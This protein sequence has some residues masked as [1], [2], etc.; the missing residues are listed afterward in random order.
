MPDYREEATQALEVERVRAFIDKYTADANFWEWLNTTAVPLGLFF[1]IGRNL[2][3]H[4]EMYKLSG[5]RQL[6]LWQY[7]VALEC[8]KAERR[9]PIMT[10][11]DE[12]SIQTAFRSPSN[13]L[14]AE[15]ATEVLNSAKLSGLPFEAQKAVFLYYLL[16]A[17]DFPELRETVIRVITESVDFFLNRAFLSAAVSAYQG[18]LVKLLA[19]ACLQSAD[20]AEDIAKIIEIATARKRNDLSPKDYATEIVGWYDEV[21]K[22][23]L[24]NTDALYPAPPF[25]PFYKLTDV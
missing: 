16:A 8:D 7:R 12:I 21:E 13:L 10:R 24:V 9:S 4:E 5:S 14:I 22:R 18:S 17:A 1:A 20:R 25:I 11:L 15:A 19:L 6:I 3:P 2:T 23:L